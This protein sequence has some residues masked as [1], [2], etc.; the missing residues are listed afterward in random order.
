[1]G[2]KLDHSPNASLKR[3]GTSTRACVDRLSAVFS[4]ATP[5]DIETGAAWYGEAQA[6]ASDLAAQGGISIETAAAVIAHLSPRTSWGRNVASAFGL[7]L[8]GYAPRCIGENVKRA[9]RAMRWADPLATLRGPKTAAFSANI[10]GDR[11]RVTI[12][13]WAARAALGPRILDPET[14]LRRAGVYGALEH[15]YTL[16]GLRH[17]VDP[18]TMQ[19]T[20][21]VVTRRTAAAWREEND[22][23]ERLAAEYDRLAKDGATW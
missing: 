22:E 18:V 15:A 16:A 13:V 11:T 4:T 23:Q 17:G 12:D 19:A 10:L 14:V 5:S 2:R 9:R 6:I 1:M 8:D 7:V 20:V 21:W 3:Q